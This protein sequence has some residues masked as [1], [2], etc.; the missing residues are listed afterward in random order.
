MRFADLLKRDGETVTALSD[1]IA[2]ADQ[3]GRDAVVR[4]EGLNRQRAEALIA[5][6]EKALDKIEREIAL[7]TRDLDRSKLALLELNRRLA[8][9]RQREHDA[10]LDAIHA[11]GVKAQETAAKLIATRYRKLAIETATLAA[12]LQQL[13]ATI[14]DVNRRLEVEGDPRRVADP[15]SVAR[16]QRGDGLPLLPTSIP[17]GLRLPHPEDGTA[18]LWPPDRDVTNVHQ[19]APVVIPMMAREDAA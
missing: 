6:D 7:A 17:N 16:P 10:R 11:E 8:V 14:A 13:E 5:D 3:A 2:R 4:L 9:A 15:D 18:F 12:E 19:P 1:A